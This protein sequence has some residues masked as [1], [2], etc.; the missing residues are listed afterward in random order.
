M[1]TVARNDARR[2]QGRMHDH[3]FLASS[4]SIWHL[5]PSVLNSI[6]R[7]LHALHA[8][9][10]AYDTVVRFVG[11]RVDLLYYTTIYRILDLLMDNRIWD[12]YGYGR[13]WLYFCS[14]SVG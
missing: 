14:T 8:V 7:Q 6:D 3:L 9:P 10:A 2:N 11:I 13:N 12:D 5:F 1:A 4:H